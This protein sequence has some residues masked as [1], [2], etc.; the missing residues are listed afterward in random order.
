MIDMNEAD[1]WGDLPSEAIQRSP[2]V[3]KW[4]SGAIGAEHGI[5]STEDSGKVIDAGGQR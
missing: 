2:Y 1:P 4:N 3:K 5:G